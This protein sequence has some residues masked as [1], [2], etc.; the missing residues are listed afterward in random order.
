[1]PV[2]LPR[3]WAFFN[4]IR[5]P[6]TLSAPSD[7]ELDEAFDNLLSICGSRVF[8]AAFVDGLDEF[9]EPPSQVVTLIESIILASPHGIKVC[10]TSRPWVEF[11]DTYNHLP[12]VR[13]DLYTIK[14]MEIC[15]QE[16]PEMQGLR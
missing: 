13:M 2:L 14:D 15:R 16:I 12:M 10:V 11:D 5:C 1:M 8:L 7:W 9:D 4:L 6:I 3:R